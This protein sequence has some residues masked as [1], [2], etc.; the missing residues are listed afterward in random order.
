MPGFSGPPDGR[1]RAATHAKRHARSTKESAEKDL[2]ENKI[3]EITG[4]TSYPKS[5]A[6][7]DPNVKKE[8][9]ELIEALQK[10][11]KEITLCSFCFNPFEI[12][13]DGEQ[14]GMCEICRDQ[15]RHQ[16]MLCIVEKESD[17]EALEKTKQYMGRYFILGGV[18]DM[19]KKEGSKNMRVE[20]LKSRAADD[21]AE[22]ILAL[23]PTAEGE[24]T[25]L[26]IE[27]ILQP[28]GKKI[29][30]LGRGLPIGGELEYAD[31]ETIRSA[32]EGRK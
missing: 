10:L 27:R 15:R 28:L 12:S 9:D 6:D 31:E 3:K 22:I 2:E 5:N 4:K 13:S 14:A 30:R 26:Y 21:I 32:L 16:G 23:N 8:I 25:C 18:Q 11:R 29:T 20:E 19:L 7:I 1:I 17:L 24:A